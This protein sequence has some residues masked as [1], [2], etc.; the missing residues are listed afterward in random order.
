MVP[1][2]IHNKRSVLQKYLASQ[3]IYATI[4]W[5]CPKELR[6]SISSTAQQIYE[7]ILCIPCDQRYNTFDMQ[8]I[9]FA[10]NRFEEQ[11]KDL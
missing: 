8:R 9:I 5:A 7:E 10:I 6:N 3:K 4:I 2:L 11:H 1:L